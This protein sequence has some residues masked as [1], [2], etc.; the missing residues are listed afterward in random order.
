[1]G[2]IPQGVTSSELTKH[3]RAFGF[4]SNMAT[5]VKCLPK[6]NVT[7]LK[8]DQMKVLRCLIG[9]KDCV[10]V[11]PT[12]YGK[13]LP[14]QMYLPVKRQLEEEHNDVKEVVLCNLIKI[15]SNGFP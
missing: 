7:G 9:K 1:M 2:H 10:A 6:L 4:A 3:M 5:S 13:S 12:G 8:E 15:R 11:L 14:F